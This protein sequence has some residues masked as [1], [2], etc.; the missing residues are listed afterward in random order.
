MIHEVM[1]EEHLTNVLERHSQH[2][3]SFGLN[4]ELDAHDRPF[5]VT[6]RDG[7][8]AHFTYSEIATLSLGLTLGE[9][10]SLRDNTLRDFKGSFLP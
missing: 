4:L 1:Q 10:R 9:Q 6:F 3:K 8:I 2:F 5:K 7:D